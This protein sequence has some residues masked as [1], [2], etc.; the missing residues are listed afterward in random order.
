MKHPFF[1]TLKNVKTGASL[2]AQ[3]LRNLPANAGDMGF[4]P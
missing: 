1:Q 2:L 3:W 4:D